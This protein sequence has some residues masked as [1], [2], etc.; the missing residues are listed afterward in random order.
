MKK[1]LSPI[2]LSLV[3]ALGLAACNKHE[4]EPA[5]ITDPAVEAPPAE[6]APGP[7]PKPK[8]KPAPAPQAAAPAPQPAPPPVCYDCGTVTAIT[9]VKTAGSGSGAGAVAGGVAGG[10]AGH[11]FGGG[12]G[13]DAATA[14]G[15]IAG[16]VA[17]HMI[18]KKARTTT[19][20]DVTIAMESGGTRVIRIP[21]L[22]NGPSVGQAV[23]VNGNTITP[24]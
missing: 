23:R 20:Y 9:E 22:D 2:V 12:R 8:P 13:K 10:V 19:D 14:L 16:A 24:R 4:E 6:E 11:Q 3:M 18:E 7:K 21:N 17:G 1:S 5:P 15:A